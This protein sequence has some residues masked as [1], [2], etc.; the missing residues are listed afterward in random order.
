MSEVGAMT[1]EPLPTPTPTPTPTV[2]RCEN[3][4]KTLGVTYLR[5][6]RRKY[7]NASCKQS[8][9]NKRKLNEVTSSA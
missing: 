6:S 2:T 7:C 5:K 9:Y 8:A 4:G 1:I 3:C